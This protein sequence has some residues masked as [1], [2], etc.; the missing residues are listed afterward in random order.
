M[1]SRLPKTNDCAHDLACHSTENSEKPRWHIPAC[2][3]ILKC[4]NEYVWR[5]SALFFDNRGCFEL[6]A[7]SEE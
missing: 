7:G 3:P 1:P 2:I 5:S 6:R 4:Y